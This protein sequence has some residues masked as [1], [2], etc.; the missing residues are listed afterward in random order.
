[1]SVQYNLCRGN[2]VG[3]ALMRLSMDI[4]AHVKEE[5]KRVSEGC[6]QDWLLGR[7]PYDQLDNGVT[8][9]NG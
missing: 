8:F 6:S 4:I 7:S 2:V 3:N 5:W 9:H 1:M